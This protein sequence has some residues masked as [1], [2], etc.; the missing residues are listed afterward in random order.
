MSK[1]K[2]DLILQTIKVFNVIL[3]LVPM[4]ICCSVYYLRQAGYLLQEGNRNLLVIILYACL[5]I[6]FGRLY[7]AF[8]ISVYRGT[9]I[10]Y[11]QFLE[12]I[13]SN[14]II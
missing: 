7:E 13:M 6:V 4:A 14:G 11:G 12:A 2:H 5:Y 9:E 1:F 10:V 3:I 8:A